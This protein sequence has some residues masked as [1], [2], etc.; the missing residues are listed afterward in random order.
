MFLRDDPEIVLALLVHQ[1]GDVVPDK[2]FLSGS[3]ETPAS[4]YCR[5]TSLPPPTRSSW[6]QYSS[7]TEL[8]V[9]SSQLCLLLESYSSIMSPSHSIMKGWCLVTSHYKSLRIVSTDLLSCT[10]ELEKEWTGLRLWRE[11]KESWA[12]ERTSSSMRISV[13]R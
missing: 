12:L 11:T 4:A 7:M 5:P 13:S 3:A 8:R 6:L 2:I 10:T 9:P 1:H